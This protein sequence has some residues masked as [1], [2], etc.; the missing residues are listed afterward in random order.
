MGYFG[1]TYYEENQD[2]LKALEVDGGR[3]LRRPER[4]RRRRPASTRRSPARS[5][6]T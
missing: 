3:R 6:S 4:R 1:F 5:S 2:T